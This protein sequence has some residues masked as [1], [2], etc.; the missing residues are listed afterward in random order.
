[1]KKYSKVIF[2]IVFLFSIADSQPIRQYGIKAGFS[3]ATMKWVTA[4]ITDNQIR[5]RLGFDVGGFIEWFEDPLF[6]FISELDYV[7]K[8]MREDIPV[9]TEQYPDGTGEFFKYDCRIDLLSFSLLPKA[10]IEMGGV[11]LYAIAGVR[12]DYSLS[13]SVSVEGEEP[14]SKYTEQAFQSFFDHFKRTQ[15]GGTFGAGVQ[16]K[17]ILPFP[18]GIE[19]RYSPNWQNT[20]SDRYWNI[21]SRSFEF[22]LTVY[23]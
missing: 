20:Y 21:R 13:N 14:F 3:L 6:S 12:L 5:N 18:A 1:M 10:R 11:E 7:Q 2:L 8:G 4:G 23:E 17:S 9:T 16:L 22:L 15:F 19:I